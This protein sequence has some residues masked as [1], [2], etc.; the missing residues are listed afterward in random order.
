M[1]FC[2]PHSTMSRGLCWACRREPCSAGP[3]T[4]CLEVE[5]PWTASSCH[6]FLSTTHEVSLHPKFVIDEDAFRFLSLFMRFRQFT[7]ASYYLFSYLLTPAPQAQLAKKV[8]CKLLSTSTCAAENWR[9]R[10][11]VIQPIVGCTL[12]PIQRSG[13]KHSVGKVC[14]HSNRAGR[15]DLANWEVL[16]LDTANSNGWAAAAAQLCRTLVEADG[17][18]LNRQWL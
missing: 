3:G 14:P 6:T 5:L 8:V 2:V 15:K 12:E 17:S 7:L 16:Q 4:R 1:C 10:N 18:S 9:K 11:S 13:V